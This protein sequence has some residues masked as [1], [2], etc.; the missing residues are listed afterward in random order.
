MALLI[1]DDCTACDACKPG[2]PERSD[3]RRR[4]AVSTCIDPLRCTECV[5]RRGRAAVQARCARPTASS[6]HP[7]FVDF[8]RIAAKRTAWPFA[9]VRPGHGA[10]HG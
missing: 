9:E 5:G 8:G 10:V 2:V 1:N 4:P 7:D 6:Q 3:R